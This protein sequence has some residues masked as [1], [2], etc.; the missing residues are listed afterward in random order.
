MECE[1][2]NSR[3]MSITPFPLSAIR[4]IADLKSFLDR[5]YKAGIKETVVP[6]A[7]SC[8]VYDNPV[9]L[10]N[11][12]ASYLLLNFIYGQNPRYFEDYI[13]DVRQILK[14]SNDYR[15]EGDYI[16][17]LLK[18]THSN[19]V[20]LHIRKTDFDVRNISTDM[21]SSV[22][23][24]N[25]IARRKG[26]S[27]FMIFGDDQK[28]MENMSQTIVESGNWDKNVYLAV[29][30]DGSGFST[31]SKSTLRHR[32]AHDGIVA[33]VANLS[34]LGSCL[35]H[36]MLTNK[37]SNYQEH[38][39]ACCPG[40]KPCSSGEFAPVLFETAEGPPSSTP[41]VITILLKKCLHCL[42]FDTP[43]E[44]DEQVIPKAIYSRGHNVP[45][46]C[47]GRYSHATQSQGCCVAATSHFATH[48]R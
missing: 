38:P 47:S 8:C 15:R 45:N 1:L 31:A 42:N 5:I 3:E 13:A 36:L 18:M 25:T 44:I 35:S 39:I 48:C 26:L 46:V 21:E 29:G 20:C 2:F 41:A 7:N 17:D 30:V 6:F 16:V 37:K 4:I 27:Q 28:F 10:S 33:A 23:A 43:N 24:A 34:F 40:G 19:L 22:E 14:F 32:A 11:N 12:N 9:R